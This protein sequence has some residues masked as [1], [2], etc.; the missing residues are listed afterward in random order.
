MNSSHGPAAAGAF[1]ASGGLTA[2]INA[3]ALAQSGQG[4]AAGSA[5]VQAT[6]PQVSGVDPVATYWRWIAMVG[7]A[8]L[9]GLP[10][11]KNPKRAHNN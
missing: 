5:A 2:A 1:T 8:A 10:C 3:A 7:F 9:V 11:F 4:G 6:V